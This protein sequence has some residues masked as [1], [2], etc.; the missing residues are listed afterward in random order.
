MNRW[1]HGWLCE[2]YGTHSP[3]AVMPASSQPAAYFNVGS[4]EKRYSL[5]SKPSYFPKQGMPVT[6]F[7]AGLKSLH[8]ASLSVP[9]VLETPGV[10]AAWLM[11]ICCLAD[12]FTPRVAAPTT[13]SSTPQRNPWKMM[14]VNSGWEMSFSFLLLSYFTFSSFF[15]PFFLPIVPLFLPPSWEV[16]LL[17][18]SHGLWLIFKVSLQVIY[19]LTL[20]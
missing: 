15:L 16:S 13:R 5:W 8:P 10:P 11:F 7:S 6:G 20:R 3:Q 19:C 9:V 14:Y 12:W 17:R 4:K 18:K 2:T 1:M